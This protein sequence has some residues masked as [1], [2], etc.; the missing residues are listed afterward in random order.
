MPWLPGLGG[1]NRGPAWPLDFQ[2]GNCNNCSGD[3]GVEDIH[4]QMLSSEY[5]QPAQHW[6]NGH[7]LTDGDSFDITFMPRSPDSEDFL[8]Q[9]A[10]TPRQ[11]DLQG[12]LEL[13]TLE[14][15]P[16]PPDCGSQT[17]KDEVRQQVREMYQGFA[18]DLYT[19]MYLT[20][21]MVDR[22]YSD[23]HCQLMED[24]STLKLDQSNGR[25]IEFPLANVSKVYCLIKRAGKLYPSDTQR[26]N[27]PDSEQIIVVVFSKRKLA[28]VF[29]ETKACERFAF[30]LELLVWRAQQ[31]EG[32]PLM[33][34]A[35]SPGSPV[36]AAEVMGQQMP[37][38]GGPCPTPRL[39]RDSALPPR[40]PAGDWKDLSATPLQEEA[41]SGADEDDMLPPDEETLDRVTE[42]LLAALAYAEANE[43][44]EQ[45]RQV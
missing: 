15:Y 24:M 27:T 2:C 8:G 1:L 9:S 23:I 19:G 41:R 18:L 44:E 17:P 28:F 42:Q 10:L 13:P 20:Q 25:I 4:V 6:S 34:S 35:L 14:S 11:R 40:P 29:K 33:R 5:S 26:H 36:V 37:L 45:Q 43:A 39:V 31:L 22:T 12:Q 7:S 3:A 21:L 30:C 16:L 32:V 38:P